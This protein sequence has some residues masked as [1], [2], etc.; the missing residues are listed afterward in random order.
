MVDEAFWRRKY[1]IPRHFHAT[2]EDV[3]AVPPLPPKPERESLVEEV[4]HLRA[5][6]A[7]E[8]TMVLTN[9]DR[10]EADRAFQASLKWRKEKRK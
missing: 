4:C 2:N 9:G 7:Y 6:Q 10:E 1:G 3:D 8:N 5:W